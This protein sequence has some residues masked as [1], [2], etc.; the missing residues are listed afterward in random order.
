MFIAGRLLLLL[1]WLG[2]LLGGPSQAPV[3]E[4]MDILTLNPNQ[5]HINRRRLA[6]EKEEKQQT[7][8]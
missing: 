5:F 7:N 8:V 1:G 6:N 3:P 2:A 4:Q